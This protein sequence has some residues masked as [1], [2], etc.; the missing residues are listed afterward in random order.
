MMYLLLVTTFAIIAAVAAGQEPEKTLLLQLPVVIQDQTFADVQFYG[1]DIEETAMRWAMSHSVTPLPLAIQLVG[2]LLR[3][4]LGEN[5]IDKYGAAKDFIMFVPTQIASQSVEDTNKT[6]YWSNSSPSLFAKQLC[7]TQGRETDVCYERVL[8]HLNEQLAQSNKDMAPKPLYTAQLTI[9]G[10]AARFPFYQGDTTISVVET[11]FQ[12]NKLPLSPED[13]D[14][15]IIA[16][17]DVVIK[18]QFFQAKMMA[19]ITVDLSGRSHTVRMFE[20]E[21]VANVAATF[22]DMHSLNKEATAQIQKLLVDTIKEKGPSGG[23]MLPVSLFVTMT[24]NQKAI[25]VK[26]YEGD[27]V[28]NLARRVITE[29]NLVGQGVTDVVTSE[30]M[31]EIERVKKRKSTT[32]SPPA[33]AAPAAPAAKST[34]AEREEGRDRKAGSITITRSNQQPAAAAAPPPCCAA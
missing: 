21:D 19:Q 12:T 3:D 23:V 33:A 9:N 32:T 7:I 27:T 2:K 18:D 31:K 6:P 10:Q 26:S 24:I 8:N 29:H 4:N 22:S 5:V 25:D 30:L 1:D 28:E 17:R 14:N 15:I 13:V 34:A 16:Y 20:H 11:W